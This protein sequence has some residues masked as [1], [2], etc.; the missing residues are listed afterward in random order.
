VN[1]VTIRLTD[2]E[3][4]YT[5]MVRSMKVNGKKTNKT[6]KEKKLGQTA[7]VTKEITNKEKSQVTVNLSGQTDLNMKVTSLRIIFMEK[8]NFR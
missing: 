1:G 7:P 5:L 2:K 8:V 3:F 6:D 4:T